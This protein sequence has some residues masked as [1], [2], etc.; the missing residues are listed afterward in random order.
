[1][2]QQIEAWLSSAEHWLYILAALVGLGTAYLDIWPRLRNWRKPLLLYVS[3][4]GTCRDPMAKAITEERLGDRAANVR[5]RSA[6]ARI[7][8]QNQRAVQTRRNGP[9][10]V[11]AMVVRDKFGRDALR[12]YRVRRINGKMLRQAR[13]IL[14]F[15]SEFR[16]DI[17]AIDRGAVM[18]AVTFDEY[19]GCAPIPNPWSPDQVAGDPAVRARYEETY[20]A[21]NSVLSKPDN[22]DKLYSQLTA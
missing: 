1:V 4:G 14:L 2:V 5:V 15:G 6:G 9:S 7:V 20:D 21:L 3:W 17:Q 8:R 12:N 19:F 22:L 11:A 10:E 18:K 16:E 13:L